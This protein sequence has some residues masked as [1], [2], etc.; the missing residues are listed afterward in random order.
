MLA[1]IKAGKMP[2]ATVINS[3]VDVVRAD[4]VDAYIAEFKRL[5]EA[6]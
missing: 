4:N 3:G 1:A 2:T 5:E 6:K